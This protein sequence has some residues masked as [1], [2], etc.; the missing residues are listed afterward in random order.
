MDKWLVEGVLALLIAMLGWF[1][2]RLINQVDEH[3]KKCDELPKS[4]I[5]EKL[6][7]LSE[8]FSDAHQENKERLNKIETQVFEIATGKFRIAKAAD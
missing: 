8:K 2:K 4:T 1:L 7:N 5:I 3:V 6:D